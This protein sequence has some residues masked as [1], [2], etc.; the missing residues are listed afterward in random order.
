MFQAEREK[1]P[2]EAEKHRADNKQYKE[3]IGWTGLVKIGLITKDK[4][5]KVLPSI[6]QFL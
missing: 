5:V 2:A 6:M 1:V 4:I 3:F